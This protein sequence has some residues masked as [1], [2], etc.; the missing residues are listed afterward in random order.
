MPAIP[1]STSGHQ[2]QKNAE[3]ISIIV[4][5]LSLDIHPSPR[6]QLPQKV[7]IKDEAERIKTDLHHQ[8]R[9]WLSRKRNLSLAGQ[10]RTVGKEINSS[11]VSITSTSIQGAQVRSES[12]C[13]SNKL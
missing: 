9:D 6:C 11:G 13:I 10:N 8:T 12:I 7:S 1:K 2:P 4:L 5:F 3:S